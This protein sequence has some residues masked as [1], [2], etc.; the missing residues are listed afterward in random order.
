MQGESLVGQNDVHIA[1]IRETKAESLEGVRLDFPKNGLPRV[2]LTLASV[3]RRFVRDEDVQ[4]QM[5]Q[6]SIQPY[7]IVT[8]Q[9]Q[10]EA[11]LFEEIDDEGKIVS[12][13]PIAF[14]PPEV[15]GFDARPYLGNR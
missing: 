11:A 4:Q 6:H 14:E 2:R 8:A 15:I 3:I 9:Y 13:E 5:F 10:L 7:M 1:G 12:T